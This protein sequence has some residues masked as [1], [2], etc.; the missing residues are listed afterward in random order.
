MSGG[1]DFK[2]CSTI[3]YFL[4]AAT[5]RGIDNQHRSSRQAICAINKHILFC[6]QDYTIHP[7]H[8]VPSPCFRPFIIYSDEGLRTLDDGPD[9]REFTI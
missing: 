7:I 9:D 4:I 8:Q 2:Y 6:V 1:N 3:H 5:S